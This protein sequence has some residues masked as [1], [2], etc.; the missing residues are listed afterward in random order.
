MSCC[1]SNCNQGRNCQEKPTSNAGDTIV[2]SLWVIMWIIS[3][4]AFFFFKPNVHT[5]T[6]NC[7]LAEISPDF[8]I[9]VKEEC[10][11]V[12]KLERL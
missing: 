3:I 8:P 11:K 1:N 12:R 4:S 6:Y 5:V 7:S 2:L 9:A 10:R